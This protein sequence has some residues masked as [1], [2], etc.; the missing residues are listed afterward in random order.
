MSV[1]RCDKDEVVTMIV[2]VRQGNV[3][4]NEFAFPTMGW[5]MGMGN[6][7]IMIYVLRFIH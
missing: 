3:H 7:S 2:S 5:L 6:G 1:D 4:G